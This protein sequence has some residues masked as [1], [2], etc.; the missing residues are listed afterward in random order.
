MCNTGDLPSVGEV[1]S[2][3]SVVLT[4]RVIEE[5]SQL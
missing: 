5:P 1:S 2:F 3:I 4:D